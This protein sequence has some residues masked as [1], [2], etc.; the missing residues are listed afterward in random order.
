MVVVGYALLT[1]PTSPVV[2]D[3]LLAG[4]GIQ[5]KPLFVLRVDLVDKLVFVLRV[6]L[7]DKL[8]HL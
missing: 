1:F 6:D 7:V 4:L 8:D 5:V 2:V 3:P